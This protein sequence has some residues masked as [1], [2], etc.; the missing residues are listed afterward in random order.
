MKKT[1]SRE[2]I[3]TPKAVEVMTP[4]GAVSLI[5]VTGSDVYVDANSNGRHLTVRGVEWGVSFNV[6]KNGPLASVRG[7]GV[8][9]KY[10]KNPSSEIAN[11]YGSRWKGAK[12]EDIT[13]AATKVVLDKVVPV[14]VAW[15]ESNPL[16]MIEA[17]RRDLSNKLHRIEEEIA[18]TEAKLIS[19][20]ENAAPLQAALE[21]AI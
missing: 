5:A 20:R 21:E 11:V 1:T 6:T 18:E 2:W 9:R 13:T 17:N 4:L 10:E 3:E 8:S 15:I 14:V 12:H 7:W 16:A 19:L